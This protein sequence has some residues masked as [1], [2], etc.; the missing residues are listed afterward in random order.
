MKNALHLTALLTLGLTLFTSSADAQGQRSDVCKCNYV[1]GSIGWMSYS[2]DLNEDLSGYLFSISRPSY[3]LFGE[4]RFHE[5]VGAKAEIGYGRMAWQRGPL[6]NHRNFRTDMYGGGVSAIMY[7]DNDVIIPASSD[8]RPYLSAGINYFIFDIR[9]DLVSAEGLTYHFWSDGTIR[10]LEETPE[11]EAVAIELERDYD[12]E[13]K[14][15]DVDGGGLFVPLEVGMH[16]R[17]NKRLDASMFYRYNLGL[18][19][20]LDGFANGS[21]DVYHHMGVSFRYNLSKNNFPKPKFPEVEKDDSDGDGVFDFMDE[22]PNTAAGVQVNS[23]GC[24]KDSDGDGVPDYLDEQ[25]DS[26]STNVDPYGVEYTEEDLENMALPMNKEDNDDVKGP[27]ND[28]N[29]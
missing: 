28:D 5:W 4:K 13:T 9:S 23:K 3:T 7:F 10:H 24:G 25:P 2:G 11:N 20:H 6:L 19:D 8:F 21:N 15:E 16:L 17:M 29:R 18:T 22:C 1:G 27:D 26:K 14:R 12:F